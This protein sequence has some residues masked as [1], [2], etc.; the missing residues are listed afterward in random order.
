MK[1][2][3]NETISLDLDPAHLA[4]AGH[5]LVELRQKCGEN[6]LNAVFVLLLFRELEKA[7]PGL[8]ATLERTIAARLKRASRKPAKAKRR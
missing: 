3:C 2:K 5:Y 6:L 4:A 7:K 1:I 8:I